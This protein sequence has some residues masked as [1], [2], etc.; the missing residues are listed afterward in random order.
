MKQTACALA[1]VLVMMGATACGPQYLS[2]DSLSV[3]RKGM[4]RETVNDKL[5][6]GAHGRTSFTEHGYTYTLAYYPI[7]T[8]QTKSTSTS[9]GYGMNGQLTTTRTTTTTDYTHTLILLYDGDRLRYWGMMGDYSKSE[10]PQILELAPAVYKQFM[11][12]TAAF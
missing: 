8:A 6:I 5:P 12:Y 2:Y 3:L 4:V 11:S 10:D 9:T 7:Q 1:L